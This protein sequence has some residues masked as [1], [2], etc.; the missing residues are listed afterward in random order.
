MAL[1]EFSVKGGRTQAWNLSPSWGGGDS[2][3]AGGWEAG[4]WRLGGWEAGGWEIAHLVR[5]GGELYN[6]VGGNPCHLIQIPCR[7]N[8]HS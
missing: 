4:G 3:Q 6:S 2:L 5:R 1:N 8:W 7:T